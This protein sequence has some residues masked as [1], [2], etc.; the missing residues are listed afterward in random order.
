[1]GVAQ[2]WELIGHRTNKN[3]TTTR[4]TRVIPRSSAANK[5]TIFT[6][7]FLSTPITLPSSGHRNAGYPALAPPALKEENCLRMSCR[8]YLD[9]MNNKKLAHGSNGINR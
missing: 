7:K 2:W 9:I 8:N 6:C 1:M 4:T 3:P 5:N